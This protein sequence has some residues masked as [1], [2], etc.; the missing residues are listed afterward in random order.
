VVTRVLLRLNRRFYDGD[1]SHLKNVFQCHPADAHPN[2][3]VRLA[4]LRWLHSRFRENGP[5]GVK[6]FHR[7]ERLINDLVPFGHDADRIRAELRYLVEAMCVLTE[8][9]RTDRLFDEDLICLSPA[10]FAHL[11]AASNFDYLAACAEDTWVSNPGLAQR[12]ASRIGEHGARG[13][14]ARET[15]RTNAVEFVT[16][17]V[18]EGRSE[19]A[20]PDKYLAGSRIGVLG[21]V[22]AIA[23][24]VA[25]RVQEEKSKDRWHEFDSKFALA[26]VYDGK[27]DGIVDYGVFVVLS[28]GPTG[29]LHRSKMGARDPQ[30]FL[31][32]DSVRVKILAIDRDAKQ[33]SLGLEQVSLDDRDR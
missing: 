11:H 16:H 27:V 14:Y 18:A 1:E 13:H 2:H 32:G 15:T 6:A 17:L 7:A 33:V 21:E 28:G 4:I 12:V 26:G 24:K 20:A 10:G 30:S 8:H 22:E 29:L 5:T 31:K 19:I 3:F 9:Q 25:R 23:D